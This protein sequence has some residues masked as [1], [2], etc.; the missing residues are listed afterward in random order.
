[1]NQRI[2]FLSLSLFFA[3]AFCFWLDVPKMRIVVLLGAI[4]ATCLLILAV[5][6]PRE[7]SAPAKLKRLA[8]RAAKKD[9]S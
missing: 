7:E 1:M 5:L 4:V 6:V 9:H 3:S 8:A 2:G